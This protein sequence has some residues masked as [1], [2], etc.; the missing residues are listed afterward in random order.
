LLFSPAKAFENSEKDPVENEDEK[1]VEAFTFPLLILVSR[2]S[3]VVVL[4]ILLKKVSGPL[5]VAAV[6]TSFLFFFFV[7]GAT[8][9]LRT[10]TTTTSSLLW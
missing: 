8:L 4:F 7:E 3:I 10:T 9:T 1:D 5:R 2:V 6:E